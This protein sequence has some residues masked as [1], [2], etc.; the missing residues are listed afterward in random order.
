MNKRCCFPPTAPRGGGPGARGGQG[1][2]P[3]GPAPHPPEP[4]A[5]PAPHP[6]KGDSPALPRS[7]PRVPELFP[8]P[9][10]SAAPEKSDGN[11][12]ASCISLGLMLA[13]GLLGGA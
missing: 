8:G 7:P 3:A 9:G 5:S 10:E 11:P 2:G 6:D 4:A 12:R 1:S 13:P